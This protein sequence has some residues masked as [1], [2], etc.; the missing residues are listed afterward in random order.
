M[1]LKAVRLLSETI[2]VLATIIMAGVS[3]YASQARFFNPHQHAFISLMALFAIAVVAIN[4]FLAFYWASKLRA[5]FFVSLATILLFIPYLSTMIQIS[6][7]TPPSYDDK[8]FSVVSYNV[9][10]FTY[11]NDYKTSLNYIAFGISQ[12]QPDIVCFQ[13]F[14]LGIDAKLEEIPNRQNI[15]DSIAHFLGMPYYALGKNGYGV[16]DLAIFSKFPITKTSSHIYENTHN[17]SMS[18]DI[19][20]RGK[21][22]RVINCHLQTTNINQ[23]RGEIA[24]LKDITRPRV[25]AQALQNLYETMSKNSIRRAAQ[26]AYVNNFTKDPDI[27]TIV[28]GDLNETPSSFVYKQVKGDLAD[29]FKEAGRGFGA[30]YKKMFG[31]IRTDYIFNSSDLQCVNYVKED[32][33]YSDHIPIFGFYKFKE[34]NKELTSLIGY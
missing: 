28:C 34:E 7:K 2:I 32:L 23:R 6:F 31:I 10:S 8:D 5:W 17:G 30:T 20:V 1:G 33:D 22:I 11:K 12:K 25:F 16:S 29:G 13:E 21:M 4:V 18:C 19:N 27:P 26:A 15:L 3:I 24:K 9:K 14:F